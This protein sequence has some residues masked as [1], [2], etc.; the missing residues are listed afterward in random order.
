M[1]VESE[2]GFGTTVRLFINLE[3]AEQEK[4]AISQEEKLED[5]V[6][7]T[8]VESNEIK[9]LVA[10]D[11]LM[12]QMIM[13]KILG[14]QSNISLEMANDGALALKAMEAKKFDLILMDLQ[15]PNMDGYEACQAIRSGALG[16]EQSEIPII[17]VT[18]DATQ[19]TRKRVFEI[20]MNAYLTK[21]VRKE[22][23]LEKIY[24]LTRTMR[25]AV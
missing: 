6:E 19:E 23:L 14:D 20:G 2:Q 10:E 21:P 18:A 9:I 7:N 3:V 24:E 5:I 17:A 15:M 1:K 4:K 8:P 16:Q 22:Q 11:N 13:K 12:N 25:V